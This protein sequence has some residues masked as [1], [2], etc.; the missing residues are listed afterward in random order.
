MI[1]RAFRF[2]S[3]NSKEGA[4]GSFSMK[5]MSLGVAALGMVS[6]IFGILAENK[7]PN[8]GFPIPGKGVV[9]CKYP[10][11]PTVILGFFSIVSLAA[12]A[13]L[14]AY[15]MFYPYKGKSA[16][17]NALFQST[18]LVVFFQIAVGVSV[19]AE[20]MMMWASITEH[21]H[22][23]RNVHN[24][25]ATKCPTAKTGLFGGGAF[26][27]L[28]ACLF[29]LI[30]LMLANNAREDYFDEQE[31]NLKGDY[32]QVLTTDYHANGQGKGIS[33]MVEA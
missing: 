21:L 27:A 3:F 16:P 29:W 5:Q 18:T 23:T 25:M 1:K 19:F 7:K 20:G 6:F 26:L 15:S 4:M 10:S 13:M 12:S 22:L 17:Q 32:G 14:G 30:C 31:E 24:N 2:D 33:R 9:T 8:E 28:D 11:D